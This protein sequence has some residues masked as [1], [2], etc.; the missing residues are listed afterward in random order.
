[1][2]TLVGVCIQFL[3]AT[4]RLP[5]RI[6]CLIVC[7]LRPRMYCKNS[8]VPREARSSAKFR[9]AELGPIDGRAAACAEGTGERRKEKGKEAHIDGRLS[10]PST[11]SHQISSLIPPTIAGRGAAAPPSREA[12]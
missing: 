9:A 3:K 1:M 12:A 2:H 5:Q 6:S 8:E 10:A 11:L 4:H 7:I